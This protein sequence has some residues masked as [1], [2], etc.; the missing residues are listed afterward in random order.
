MVAAAVGAALSAAC[1]PNSVRTQ[2]L[3][4]VHRSS[5]TML[6]EGQPFD[7]HLAMP[8]THKA[9]D[10]LIVYASGD[11]GWFGAAVHMFEQI[12]RNGYYTAGFS[13]RA[14]LNLKRP[15]G[16]LTTLDRL[17]DDYESIIGRARSAM[18]L[19]PSTPTVLTGWSRGAAFAVLVASDPRERP[20]VAGAV[21]IGLGPGED[22]T[23][24][25]DEG[26]DDD[27]GM[28]EFDKGHRP[29]FDTYHLM[30][31]SPL[32]VALIQ[33]TGDQYLSASEARRLF[34]DDSPSRRFFAIEAR[35][36]RFSGATAQFDRALESALAW[37]L[38]PHS[39]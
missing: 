23:K 34:G 22:L 9:D 7:L 13:S 10:A 37:I 2:P 5:V 15:S 24:S 3:T 30:R 8:A 36:H 31:S 28:R 39:P 16:E 11:G 4:E 21:A 35:N 20:H 29:S 17:V 6:L 12:G 18:G 33:A 19:P 32:R 25:T 38:S 26:D 14:F 27:G 1:G